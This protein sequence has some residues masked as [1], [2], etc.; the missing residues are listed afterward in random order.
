MILSGGRSSRMD[1]SDKGAIQVNGQSMLDHALALAQQQSEDVLISSNQNLEFYQN[2]GYPVIKDRTPDRAGPL[3]GIASGL[4]H[5][6]TDLLLVLPIDT[7]FLPTDIGQRLLD[8]LN[9]GDCALAFAATSEREHYLHTLIRTS[10]QPVLET[11]LASGKRSAWGWYEE[12]DSC[13]VDGFDEREFLNLN[14]LDS[15]RTAEGLSRR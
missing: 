10:I 7:P 4:A 6:K 5:C 1:G 9:H 8:A 13:R 15:L 2:R 3:A 12:T 14:D 11:Y